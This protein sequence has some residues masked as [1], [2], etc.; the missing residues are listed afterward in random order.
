MPH[1]IGYAILLDDNSHNYA[2]QMELDLSQRFNTRGGLRQSPHI[3]IKVPFS[4]EELGPFVAYFDQIAKETEPFNIVLT[5]VD[6]FEPN[7]IFINVEKN[8]KL[9][10]F[11]ERIITDLKKNY[12]VEPN[13]KVEGENV[14][15]HSSLAVSDLTEENFHKAKEY[16]KNEN[17]YF[18]FNATTLALFYH[19]SSE[20]GWIIYKRTKL[21]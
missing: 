15:F 14:R 8:Q 11:H 17:P 9:Q 12:G 13:L 19:L 18:N 10:D 5:G 3:T 4:A 20:E 7:V 1:K 21:E 6:Y 16:L 2:R